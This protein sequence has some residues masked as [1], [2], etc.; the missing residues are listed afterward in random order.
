MTDK[1]DVL[2]V[3]EI[4]ERFADLRKWNNSAAEDEIVHSHE[5]LRAEN[6]ALRENNEALERA[7]N[8]FA[9]GVEAYL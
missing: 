5:S 8:I 7:N 1:Q 2:T 3:A 9:R 6:K 4:R